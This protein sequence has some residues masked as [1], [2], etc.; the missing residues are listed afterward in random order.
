[1]GSRVLVLFALFTQKNPSILRDIAQFTGTHEIASVLS[2]AKS[3]VHFLKVRKQ[4]D[5]IRL[6]SRSKL[7][8][9]A[10]QATVTL[11]YLRDGLAGKGLLDVFHEGYLAGRRFPSLRGNQADFPLGRIEAVLP[12]RHDRAVAALS[13]RDCIREEDLPDLARSLPDRFEI[14]D[15]SIIL[16]VD[17]ARARYL[18][19]RMRKA[20]LVVCSS[21]YRQ[22]HGRMTLARTHR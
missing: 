9:K 5:L 4:G 11:D 10:R 18:I 13:K 1:M 7:R 20:R 16:K 22:H 6:S 15:A 8:V 2:R 21:P 12:A 3:G 19:R 17:I 14:I